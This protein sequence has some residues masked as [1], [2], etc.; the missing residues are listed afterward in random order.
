MGGC[1]PPEPDS[2]R[3]HGEIPGSNP[4]R[5]AIFY[6]YHVVMLCGF[7][8]WTGLSLKEIMPI[9]FGD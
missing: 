3:I 2:G 6:L 1:H 9:Y 5:G 4:G 8:F 7:I